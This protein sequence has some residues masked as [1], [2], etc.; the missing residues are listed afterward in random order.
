MRD[1]GGGGCSARGANA[2]RGRRQGERECE[3]HLGREQDLARE[4]Q[5]EPPCEP[6]SAER[7]FEVPEH[8][9]RREREEEH[10]A[11]VHVALELTE[12]VAREAEQVAARERGPERARQMTAEQER[13]PRRE[14]RHQD[15]GDVVGGDRAG[16]ER[17]GRERKREPR[18]RRDPREVEADRRPDRVRE[19]R[20]LPVENRV[21]PPAERPDEDLRVG[22]EADPVAAWMGG[23]RDAEVQERD[24]KVCRQRNGCV[25]RSLTAPNACD[26]GDREAVI[27]ATSC[28]GRRRACRRAPRP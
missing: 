11:H 25:S 3:E 13:R 8:D 2:K 5:A 21:R 19:D 26:A 17:Y 24:R 28:S 23:D 15:R 18:N 7:P 10:R 27:R 4:Q 9:E 16:E 22:A 6:A 14:R 1:A 12:H 20:V